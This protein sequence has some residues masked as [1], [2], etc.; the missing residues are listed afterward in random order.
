MNEN[1]DHWWYLFLPREVNFLLRAGISST[2]LY[3]FVN[4]HLARC[5]LYFAVIADEFGVSQ[6]IQNGHH[7]HI[8][9]TFLDL[10]CLVY[11]N[12]CLLV[13]DFH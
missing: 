12:K 9:L 8:L 6:L 10:F 7:S 3:L 2:R 5:H 13:E 11:Y 4:F 1:R